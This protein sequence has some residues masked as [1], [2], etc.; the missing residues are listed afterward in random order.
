[1]INLLFTRKSTK[2]KLNDKTNKKNS[3]PLKML[4]RTKKS[5]SILLCII[6]Y[7]GVR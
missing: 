7:T 3:T 5:I 2:Q 6:Y 1:M 4:W